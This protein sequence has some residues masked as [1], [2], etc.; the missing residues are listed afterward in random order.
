M[1]LSPSLSLG[2]APARPV[3][4]RGQGRQSSSRSTRRRAVAR[5]SPSSGGLVVRFPRVK[6]AR[7]GTD[8]GELGNYVPRSQ[9]GQ[10]DSIESRRGIGWNECLSRPALGPSCECF[11]APWRRLA[12]PLRAFRG[13]IPMPLTTSLSGLL[14]VAVAISFAASSDGSGR[15]QDRREPPAVRR[16]GRSQAPSYWLPTA[17]AYSAWTQSAIPTWG[18]RSR[19]KPTR[20]SGSPRCPSR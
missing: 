20:F 1:H 12:T 15:S 13:I 6:L 19:C 5:A 10:G 2:H 9:T 4:N 7:N 14:V 11:R 18:P 8:G 17:M 3:R 16:P